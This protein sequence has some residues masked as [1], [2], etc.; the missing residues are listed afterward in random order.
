MLDT[1]GLEGRWKGGL[2]TAWIQL[3]LYLLGSFIMFA[4]AFGLCLSVPL[5]TAG[6]HVESHPALTDVVFGD[7][8][9][10]D[11]QSARLAHLHA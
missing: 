2:S 5:S 4:E 7:F 11:G 1:T 8:V 10:S 3:S 9:H 6:Q